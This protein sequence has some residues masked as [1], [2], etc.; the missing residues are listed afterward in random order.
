M[1]YKIYRVGNYIRVEYSD[2]TIQQDYASNVIV[3][4]TGEGYM[5]E[6][7]EIGQISASISELF[8]QNNVAHTTATFQAL[9]TLTNEH[10]END[11]Y[12][13][14][15][16]ANHRVITKVGSKLAVPIGLVKTDIWDAS[17][18]YAHP[19]TAQT[20]SIVSTSA[21][22]TLAGTGAQ[23]VTIVGLNSLFVEITETVN[24]N[25][26]TPVTT[27]SQFI[28]VNAF[29]V[30]Q[31]GS[32]FSNVGNITLTQSTSGLTM[33]FILATYSAAQNSIYTIPAG[34]TG[35]IKF[36]YFN[37]TRADAAPTGQLRGS[38][39]SY[40]PV[41]NVEQQGLFF[42]IEGGSSFYFDSTIPLR[43]AE[44]TTFRIVTTFAETTGMQSSVGYVLL[45]IKN[46]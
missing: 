5:I 1:T 16:S 8:D 19:P 36:G 4:Y 10:N 44:K 11:A 28:R 41:T 39:L 37:G 46:Q 21:D 9:Y 43:I 26:L 7:K 30:T 15:L 6:G 14:G 13:L 12:S 45:L 22:D 23:K 38:T 31:A 24:M 35:L 2:G 3:T 27:T 29:V 42:N 25:G 40:S 20:L 34:W 17:V 18:N 32:T 33:S